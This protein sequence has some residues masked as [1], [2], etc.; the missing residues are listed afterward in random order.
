EPT[1]FDGVR[2]D[3]TIAREEIFGPVVSVIPF[4]DTDEV[5]RI[6]NDTPYGLAAAVWTKDIRKA[7]R[8]A[9][10]ILC[11]PVWINTHGAL[12]TASPFG[13]YKMSG[14]GRELGAA[15]I[16]LYTQLKSVWVDLS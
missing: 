12:D 9:R 5:I 10:Q 8:A 7:H 1:I 15:G 11:G 13:G 4:K 3:M 2:N 6:G 14:Y 16:D